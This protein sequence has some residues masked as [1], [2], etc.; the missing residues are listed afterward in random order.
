MTTALSG[1]ELARRIHDQ[2]PGA[3][4]DVQGNAVWVSPDQVPQVCRWLAE[5]PGLEFNY[6]SSITG[7]DYIEY[8][9]VVYHLTSLVQNHSAVLKTRVYGRDNPTIPSVTGIWRGANFQE[10]EVWDLVGI[11]FA[12]HPNLKRIMLW[13]GFPG[14]PLRRDFLG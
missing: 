13:E 4:E 6:L 14:H 3:V 7:V 12:G 10:R 9:E 2:L 1:A 8:F 5:A 11:R